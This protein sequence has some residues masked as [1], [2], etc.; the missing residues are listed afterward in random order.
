MGRLKKKKAP[1]HERENCAVQFSQKSMVL[2]G[3][4]ARKDNLYRGDPGKKSQ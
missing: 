1:F 4:L 3:D 2:F